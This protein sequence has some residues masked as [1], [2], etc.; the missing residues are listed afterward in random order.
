MR[1]SIQK[2]GNTYYAV[3][4]FDGKRKWIKGGSTKKDAERV[5]NENLHAVEEGTFKELPKATLKEFAGLWLT[6]HVEGNLKPS[7]TKGYTEIITKKLSCFNSMPISAITTGHL[8]AYVA[9]RKKDPARQRAKGSIDTAIPVSAKTI[10]NEIMVMKELFRHARKWGYIKVNPAEDVD[11]PK[12]RSKEIDILEPDEFRTLLEKVHAHYRV[13]FLTAFLTGI[14]AGELWALKWGDIDWN[15]NRLFIRRALWHGSF[16]L[17]KSKKAVRK[18]DIPQQLVSELRRWKLACPINEDDLVFPAIRGGTVSHVNV[19][20]QHFYPALR[21][22]GLRQ[23]SFHSLRHSNA[24]LRIQAGQNIKYISE[25][26]GHSTIRI[27]LDIY[28]HLFNDVNFTRQQ[29]ELLESSFG[30]VRN[31]LENPAINK[32]DDSEESP[33]SLKILS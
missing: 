14:G 9:R 33:K 10:C 25:Q 12:V 21:R 5:L 13:A 29:V 6:S 4:P 2:K 24:S 22:A 31:P 28:G 8:Q 26:L 19:M 16:Q 23:V 30:S 1:G 27:T 17:P 7:T 11:R 3:I 15:S 32:K 18:I 20:N